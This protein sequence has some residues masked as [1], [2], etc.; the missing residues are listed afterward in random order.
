MDQ[1]AR[2]LIEKSGCHKP[3]TQYRSCMDKFTI[4]TPQEE[5]KKACKKDVMGVSVCVADYVRMQRE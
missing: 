5:V 1:I 3:Y 4:E 2:T